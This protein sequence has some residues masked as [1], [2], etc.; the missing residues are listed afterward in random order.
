M[1]DLTLI[2][3]T[4]TYTRWFVSPVSLATVDV[5]RD[6]KW[7]IFTKSNETTRDK[8][9]SDIRIDPL[10][11]CIVRAGER[12]TEKRGLYFSYLIF[13]SRVDSTRVDSRRCIAYPFEQDRFVTRWE[14]GA[15]QCGQSTASICFKQEFARALRSRADIERKTSAR[16]VYIERRYQSL[17][18][19]DR[20]CALLYHRCDGGVL[21]RRLR[22]RRPR[23]FFSSPRG[24]KQSGNRTATA[25][26]R[27]YQ[28]GC[29]RKTD[30][31]S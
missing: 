27:T 24:T 18:V 19:R 10:K 31:S 6:T 3:P 25:F 14:S 12:E 8:V 2:A 22:R 20:L 13:A 4:I 26:E 7:I 29:S 28:L 30:R 16:V 15:R 17:I 9:T 21:L 11:T 23:R 1:Y 5:S